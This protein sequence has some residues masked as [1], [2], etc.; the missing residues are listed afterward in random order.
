[1][2]NTHQPVNGIIE[3]PIR[4]QLLLFFFPILLGTFF[5]QLYNT[6]DAVVVGNFIGKEALAAVGGSTSVLI[7]LL[8]GL[9]V[10][11]A[12][13]GSVVIAQYFGENSAEKMHKAIHTTLALGL[14]G[15]AFLM[16]LGLLFSPMALR[17]TG[18][19][20]DVM[21]YAVTYM[22]IYFLGIIGNLVY[23]LG[24]GVLRAVGDS[25][26]PLYFLILCTVTNL[27]LDLLFVAVF[28]W[29]IAGV[30]WATI[31][32]QFLS[33]G[34]IVYKLTHANTIYHLYLTEIRFD[35]PT[36]KQIIE[37]G[38]PNGLQSVM[39]SLSNIIVQ[40]SINSFGTDTIA[41]WTAYGKADGLF[42][43]I[44]GAFGIAAT[45]FS[46]QNFGAKQYDRIRKSV[47]V[48][49]N[50]S[51][52]FSVGLS[53]IFYFSG[54]Y[55]YRLFIQDP[56]VIAEGVS[57]MRTVVPFYF[58]YIFIEILSGAIR[59]T[60]DSLVPTIITSL[61]ICGIRIVWCS[62][63]VPRWHDIRVVALS[64]P[65]AWI[66]TSLAFIAYYLW[67]G[68]MERRIKKVQLYEKSSPTG[69]NLHLGG[70]T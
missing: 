51:F 12:S 7:N 66:V 52:T 17:I 49:L 24:A 35:A 13:G 14:T 3:G 70:K 26:S 53:L 37:I 22:R 42:W 11:V 32:S 30:A 45:T 21:P 47:R 56:A 23:N 38:L 10:G 59:G 29:G 36:L 54:S 43:M 62:F 25:K 4:K 50:L 15:G 68:W 5:Q 19:P 44:I 20:E 41:A 1:M 57:I 39:Y 64:Y 65:A 9:F 18:T 28:H 8:V 60:G 16:V 61:G 46:G 34:M 48:G 40:V 67:G 58:T 31:L 27:V 55:I 63:I 69:C 6:V 33:A 2:E